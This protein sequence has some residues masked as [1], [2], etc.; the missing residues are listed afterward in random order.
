MQENFNQT[1][2][3]EKCE[4]SLKKC[5]EHKDNGEANLTSCI[6]EFNIVAVTLQQQKTLFDPSELPPLSPSSENKT[7]QR[8]KAESIPNAPTLPFVETSEPSVPVFSFFVLFV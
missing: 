7:H 3:V 4:E 1:I 2:G 6:N 5:E 8:L